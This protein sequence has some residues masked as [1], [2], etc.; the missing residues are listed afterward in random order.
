MTSLASPNLSG[1]G[2]DL[3]GVKL[4]STELELE[5]DLTLEEFERLLGLLEHF[6]NSSPW[7]VGDLLLEGEERYGDRVF[8]LLDDVPWRHA[9]RQRRLRVSMRVAPSVRE[10][11]L[12]W[13]HHHAVSVLDSPT[14]QAAWLAQALGESWTAHELTDRLRTD[15]AVQATREAQGDPTSLME[16][17]GKYRKAA[18]TLV[19][20]LQDRSDD[21]ARL[22]AADIE[23]LLE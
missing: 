16:W 14:D 20:I 21:A 1:P 12:S 11:G 4:S 5:E 23:S 19:P 8:Q 17:I 9:T 10:E 6:D 13:S 18:A 7:W 3:P 22:L 15:E 2:L